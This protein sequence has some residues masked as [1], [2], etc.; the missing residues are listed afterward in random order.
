MH[1]FIV[2]SYDFLHDYGDKQV[3]DRGHL[4]VVV[5]YGYIADKTSLKLRYFSSPSAPDLDQDIS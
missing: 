4:M 1:L 2:Y 5:F 3:V